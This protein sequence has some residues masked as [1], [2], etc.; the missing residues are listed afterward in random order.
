MLPFTLH[1]KV[2]LKNKIYKL[3]I[4]ETRRRVFPFYNH[5]PLLQNTDFSLSELKIRLSTK[6]PSLICTKERFLSLFGNDFTPVRR[7]SPDI[8]GVFWNK[9]VGKVSALTGIT[10]NLSRAFFSRKQRQ[11]KIERPL[12]PWQEFHANRL[13]VSRT[14]SQ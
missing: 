5:L 13:A 4:N 11:N 10:I 6:L 2:L 9:V 3:I 7:K 12:S 14:H 8:G 1:F